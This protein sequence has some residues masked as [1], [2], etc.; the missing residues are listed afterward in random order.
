M[1]HRSASV[2]FIDDRE[3]LQQAV[4]RLPKG[5]KVVLL[6]DRGFVHTDLMKVLTTQWGWHYRIRVKND[7]WIWRADALAGVNSKTS[8]SSGAKLCAFTMSDCIKSKNRVQ[9]FGW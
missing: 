8:I 7:T 3:M 5:V 4:E 1:E 6:A 2:S 9:C